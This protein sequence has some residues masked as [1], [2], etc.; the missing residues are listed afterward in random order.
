[1]KTNFIVFFAWLK[2]KKF[3]V[4]KSSS[5]NSFR[6]YFYL[7]VLRFVKNL[8]LVLR[9]HHCKWR[10]ANLDPF[11]AFKTYISES[12]FT[13]QFSCETVALLENFCWQTLGLSK[14][15]F[16]ESYDFAATYQCPSRHGISV[17][18]VM[19][20]RSLIDWLIDWLIDRL[21]T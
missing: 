13:Y 5:V 14:K 20:E 18:K 9:C 12:S 16:L 6:M 19:S 15:N 2:H 3:V 4:K 11:L 21:I 7:S 8:L 1:M 17:F 10:L